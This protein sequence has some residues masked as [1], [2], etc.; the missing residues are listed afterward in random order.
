MLSQVTI[1]FFRS[2]VMPSKFD[3]FKNSPCVSY[4]G[5][6]DN[7]VSFAPFRNSGKSM[8]TAGEKFEADVSTQRLFALSK[9]VYFLDDHD[10]HGFMSN[11]V[12]SL[13]DVP[14][15]VDYTKTYLQRSNSHLR[16][17]SVKICTAPETFEPELSTT[18]QIATWLQPV[19]AKCCIQGR[20]A[21]MVSASVERAA[22]GDM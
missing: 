16:L 13:A 4:A 9:I 21:M 15:A 2:F 18:K 10:L 22:V 19:K 7:Y 20:Y 12:K 17:L 3:M 1:V 8:M 14:G 11:V 5:D 6:D